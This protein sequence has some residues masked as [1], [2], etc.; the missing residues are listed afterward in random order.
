MHYNLQA[1]YIHYVPWT[2][3]LVP[4]VATADP[5]EIKKG[6]VNN[7]TTFNPR[8]TFVGLALCLGFLNPSGA[9][10]RA[11]TPVAPTHP[12][13]IGITG[14]GVG[15]HPWALLSRHPLIKLHCFFC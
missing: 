9:I 12:T 4:V 3:A 10:S 8:V 15:M 1:N 7:G 13:R 5:F 2:G 11:G 6:I 14:K